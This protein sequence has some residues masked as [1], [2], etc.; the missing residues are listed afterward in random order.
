[1][2]GLGAKPEKIRPAK[3]PQDMLHDTPKGRTTAL[4]AHP[5]DAVAAIGGRRGA[6]ALAKAGRRERAPRVK[7]VK[8][9]AL[10]MLLKPIGVAV[11]LYLRAPDVTLSASNHHAQRAGFICEMQGGRLAPLT[12]W[13]AP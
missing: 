13:I 11:A 12:G 2:K 7:V 4:V 6:R 9:S 8:P 5:D 10:G 1:M 3:V